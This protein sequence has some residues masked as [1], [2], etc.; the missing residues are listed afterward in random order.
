MSSGLSD[1]REAV[2]GDSDE[3]IWPEN[4]RIGRG[5]RAEVSERARDSTRT[6]EERWSRE[7]IVSFY[8]C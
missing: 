7:S 4:K 2:S 8:R 3:G 6:E 1:R 5:T